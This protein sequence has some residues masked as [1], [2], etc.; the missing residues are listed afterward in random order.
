MNC[1]LCQPQ[2]N[3]EVMLSNLISAFKT[4]VEKLECHINLGMFTYY[5]YQYFLVDT[6]MSSVK[7]LFYKTID[8]N[9]TLFF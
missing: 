3:N 4:I 6:L 7:I 5:L 1:V 9:L 8:L 2:A